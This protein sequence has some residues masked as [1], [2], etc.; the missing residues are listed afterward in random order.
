MNAARTWLT[1]TAFPAAAPALI[2]AVLSVHMR[3]RE[4]RMKGKAKIVFP[5]AITA[6][7][8]TA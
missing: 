2:R 8:G 7:E 5:V 1:G 4:G 6:I 3:E